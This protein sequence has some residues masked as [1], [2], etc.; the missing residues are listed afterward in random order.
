MKA[1]LSVLYRFEDILSKILDLFITVCI[2]VVFLGV[3]TVTIAR[4]V[5]GFSIMGVAEI[6]L[7]LFV[8]A[9]AI[10]SSLLIRSGGNISISYFVDLFPDNIR[11]VLHIVGLL[12]TALMNFVFAHQSIA[13]VRATMSYRSMVTNIPMWVSEIGIPIGCSLAVLFAIIA[14][15]KLIFD[16]DTYY[17]GLGQ[18][19]NVT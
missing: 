2:I 6:L 7:I 14:V 18:T 1:F 19:E 17:K 5:F 11:R 3:F 12:A 8:L 16:P 9:N 13:W 10:G 15:I 4:Y